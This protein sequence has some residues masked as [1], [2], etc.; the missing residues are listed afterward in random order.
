MMTKWP[1][2]G[3]FDVALCEKMETLIQ[4]HKTKGYSKKRET[5]REGS[6][7]LIQKGRRKLIKKYKTGKKNTKTC[8]PREKRRVVF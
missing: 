4:N 2:E 1:A 5:K 3:T 6:A 7:N 8:R